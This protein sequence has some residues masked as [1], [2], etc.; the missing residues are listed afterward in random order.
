MFI[1]HL[2]RNLTAASPAIP[3]SLLQ[4]KTLFL[5][6]QSVF[7]DFLVV[8]V[9]G[10]LLVLGVIGRGVVGHGVVGYAFVGHA[11]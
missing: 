4:G 3:N 8:S 10:V 2:P 9:V 1:L 11:V 5:S 6:C 7:I